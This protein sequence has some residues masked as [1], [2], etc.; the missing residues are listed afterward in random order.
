MIFYILGLCYY[1]S[2][3]RDWISDSNLGTNHGYYPYSGAWYHTLSP[4]NF[5]VENHTSLLDVTSAGYLWSPY[6][7]H[8][9]GVLLF[10]YEL[11]YYKF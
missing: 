10:W 7:N 11:C 4:S 2:L 3:N 1:F 5:W 8:I 9:S 6:I